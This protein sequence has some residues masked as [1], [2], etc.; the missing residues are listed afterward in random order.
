M[1]KQG[2]ETGAFG[3]WLTEYMRGIPKYANHQVYYDHG[4]TS[5]ETNVAVP[6]GIFGKEATNLTRLADVDVMIVGPGNDIVVLFEIEERKVSPKEI[7]GNTFACL[8]SNKFAVKLKEG[9]RYFSI[10]PTTRLIVA[11]TVPDDG[12]RLKKIAETI[13]PR[14]IAFGGLPDAISPSNVTLHFAANLADTIAFLK[15]LV[16]KEFPACTSDG[17]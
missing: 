10:A 13:Q 8:I 4:D 14:I 7:L 2:V 1:A 6:K 3:K 12:V 9:Q 16:L 15:N 17:R 5:V 11:G